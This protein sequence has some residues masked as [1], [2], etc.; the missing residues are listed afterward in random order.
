VV[1]FNYAPVATVLKADFGLTEAQLGT[2]IC[3]VA[4]TIPARLLSAWLD[5]YGRL[6]THGC[7][8]ILP[9]RLAFALAQNFDQLVYSRL[10]LSIGCGFV[11]GIRMVAEWF[12]PQK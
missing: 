12:V 9:F 5:R 2:L 8:F 7:W 3:N 1:W 4:L 6:P 11:I 10:A